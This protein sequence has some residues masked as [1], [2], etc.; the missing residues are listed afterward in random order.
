MNELMFENV[1]EEKI[2]LNKYFIW[3][4]TFMIESKIIRE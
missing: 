4:D 3:N 1:N 2:I